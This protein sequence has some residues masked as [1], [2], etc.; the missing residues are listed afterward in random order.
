MP[1][2]IYSR[3]PNNE[4]LSFFDISK[5]APAAFADRP[6]EG[7]SDRYGHFT[8]LDAIQQLGSNGWVPVQ[9]AQT[10]ART[11]SAAQHTRHLIA[12]ARQA[13]L[14]RPEGRPEIVLYNSSDRSSSLKLYAGFY[15]WIC[16][17]SLVAGSGSEAKIYHT[18]NKIK[19]I[20]DLLTQTVENIDRAELA[21][22]RM[23]E[24]RITRDHALHLAN[25]ALGIRWKSLRKTIDSLKDDYRGGLPK[26]SYYS[27]RTAID[28]LEPKR[29]SEAT[30]N[31]YEHV[32]LW[33][34]FNRTQESLMRGGIDIF[35]VTNRSPQGS[36]RRARAIQSV[37]EALNV[38][39]KCWDLFESVAA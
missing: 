11:K 23:Q 9:A 10:A 14:Y 27:T 25:E 13:D 35:S 15:R 24:I 4:A 33:E 29:S 20:E 6:I 28:V 7:V 19:G 36:E 18:K 1:D 3:K 8:T 26:G 32:S 30:L 39:R 2:L 21:R 22:E 5:Q 37:A 17:N 16:S 38:N 12:F 34:A 31:N